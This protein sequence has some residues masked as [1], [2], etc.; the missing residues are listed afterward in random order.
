MFQMVGAA[1]SKSAGE[2]EDECCQRARLICRRVNMRIAENSDGVD[3]GGL[4]VQR[5]CEYWWW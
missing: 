3:D 5:V 1:S 4:T 2:F